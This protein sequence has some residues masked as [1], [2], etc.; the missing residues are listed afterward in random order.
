VYILTRLTCFTLALLPFRVIHFL[1]KAAGSLLFYLIPKFRKR[2]LSN[3]ALATDLALT[4]EEIP[5]VAKRSFQ[6]LA[7]SALEF[8]KFAY[9][10]K[11]PVIC[12]N[13]DKTAKIIESGKGVIYFC[14]HQANWE[15]LFLEGTQRMPGVAIG[16]PIHNL[17]VYDWISKVRERFGGTMI[18]PKDASKLGLS[19][20]KSG[21]F[22]GIVGDQGMPESSFSSNFLGRNAYTSTLPGLLAYKA[23]VPIVFAETVREKGSYIITYSEPIW[24]DQSV[25]LKQEVKRMMSEILGH[26]EES[27]K[28]HPEQW[29]WQHNRWKQETPK[30]VFYRFRHDTILILIPNRESCQEAI[31]TIKAIYPRAFITVESENFFLQDYKFKLVF[32]F[33]GVDVKKHYLSKSAFE[34]I[35]REMLKS[36]YEGNPPEDLPTL[37]I[38]TICRKEQREKLCQTIATSVPI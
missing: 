27:I 35:D 19:A 3:L 8:G 6:S 37:L 10:K 17:K 20:L 23:N 26:L 13:P 30:N 38:Q 34:V 15:L 4:N 1:G 7:I 9:C 29:L 32:N 11:L 24:P 36:L 14:A 31:A 22:L 25:S 16:R 5:R 12:K 28:A 2:A 33:T 21:K 18:T